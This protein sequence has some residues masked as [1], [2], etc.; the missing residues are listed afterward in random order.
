MQDNNNSSINPKF[1][2]KRITNLPG[3]GSF[4]SALMAIVRG[5]I[6]GFF[7]MLAAAPA[8]SVAGFRYV[9]MGGLGRIGDVFYFATPILMTGL[10][11]GFAF[12]IADITGTLSTTAE[13]NPTPILDHVGPNTSGL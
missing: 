9:L 3:F 8:N 10:A 1:N 6:F 4:T 11:V 12:K 5:L 2:I 7:V 13:R